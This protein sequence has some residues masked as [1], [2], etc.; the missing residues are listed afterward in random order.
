MTNGHQFPKDAHHL[1]FVSLG[2]QI[3]D[4]CVDTIENGFEQKG[5]FVDNHQVVSVES[6]HL[7]GYEGKDEEFVTAVEQEI[8]YLMDEDLFGLGE[9]VGILL[10]QDLPTFYI[11]VQPW[12]FLVDFPIENDTTQY[13]EQEFDGNPYIQIAIS[14][15]KEYL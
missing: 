8:L 3:A 11:S 5:Y 7:Q 13:A 1:R 2:Y 6:N 10:D 15:G 12:V 9:N 14:V 4:T